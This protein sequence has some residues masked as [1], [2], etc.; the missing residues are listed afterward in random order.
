MIFF[1]VHVF[2]SKKLHGKD[3]YVL[4]AHVSNVIYEI[5]T[6]RATANDRKMSF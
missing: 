2:F 1:L 3:L 4:L 6:F 5:Q